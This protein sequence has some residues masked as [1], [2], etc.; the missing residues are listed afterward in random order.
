MPNGSGASFSL[1]P[2]YQG[3][4]T[5]RSLFYSDSSSSR[6]TV[7]NAKLPGLIDPSDQTKFLSEAPAQQEARF[8]FPV[9]NGK[10][11]VPVSEASP[12]HDPPIADHWTNHQGN[13]SAQSTRESWNTAS[14]SY[15]II[16]WPLN[17][18]LGSRGE[19]YTDEVGIN[20]RGP[21]E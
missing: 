19:T 17:R 21:G 18:S 9:Q 4:S 7:K 13:M 11:V 1:K 20:F 3:G 2:Q 15:K 8:G 6:N 14:S 16:S 5:I 12:D 10:A